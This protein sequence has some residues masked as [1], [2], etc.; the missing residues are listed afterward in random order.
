MNILRLWRRWKNLI[1]KPQLHLPVHYSQV[2]TLTNLKDY[3][4]LP[5]LVTGSTQVMRRILKH[6]TEKLKAHAYTYYIIGDIPYAT[7]KYFKF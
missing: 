3:V 5:A 4:S 2:N 6:V 1:Y 7:L